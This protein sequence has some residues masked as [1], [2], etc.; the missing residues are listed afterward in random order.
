[1]FASKDGTYSNSALYGVPLTHFRLG[2]SQTMKLN[3]LECLSATSFF[4]LKFASEAG[5]YPSGVTQRWPN[6]KDYTNL[7]NSIIKSI[8]A[9]KN[10]LECLSHRSS[11]NALF[12]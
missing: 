9:L 12:F 3:K 8:L 7:L 6:H 11:F 2:S 4:S 5:T 1:M 10:K